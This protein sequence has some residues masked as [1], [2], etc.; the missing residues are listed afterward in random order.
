MEN[1]AFELKE[2]FNVEYDILIFKVK[3]SYEYSKTVEIKEGLLL[4]FDKDNMPVAIE[5]HDA[6]KRFNIPKIALK[7]IRC[8]NMNIIVNDDVIKV[9]MKLGVIIRSKEKYESLNYLIDNVRNIPNI[10]TELVKA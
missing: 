6:S 8:F 1:K 3:K 5:I 10:E 9:F 7:N 4:D 2:I